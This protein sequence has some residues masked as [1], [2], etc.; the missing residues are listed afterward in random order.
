MSFW[1]FFE[2]K[3]SE[4]CRKGCSEARRYLRKARNESAD[5]DD[6]IRIKDES[7]INCINENLK[8]QGIGNFIDEISKL[9]EGITD[10]IENIRERLA[11]VYISTSK[12]GEE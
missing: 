3:P 9:N 7:I 6:I 12:D 10:A 5:V 8:F 1:D 11:S 4:K 2:D